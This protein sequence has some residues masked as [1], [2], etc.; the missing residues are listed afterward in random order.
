LTKLAGAPKLVQF[1]AQA[2]PTAQPYPRISGGLTVAPGPKPPSLTLRDERILAHLDLVDHLARILAKNLPPCFELD[3]LKGAGYIGLIHAAERYRPRRKVS[4]KTYARYRI[5]DAIRDSIRRRNWRDATQLS[6][7]NIAVG[8]ATD[9]QML[10]LG[11]EDTLADPGELPDQALQRSRDSQAIMGA[12][13]DLDP[14]Q[15]AVIHLV[16]M[17]GETPERI[18]ERMGFD[19]TWIR[20][21]RREAERKMKQHF[22]VRGRKA[23]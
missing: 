18:G 5:C 1:P 6:L 16:Y 14:R 17:R 2:Q 10:R 12:L 3:D 19:A 7:E 20:R 8:F 13:Q 15:R 22:A 9:G 4:F 21:I 23:A 11:P